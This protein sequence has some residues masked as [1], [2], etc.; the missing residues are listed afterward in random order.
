MHLE[1]PGTIGGA[2]REFTEVGGHSFHAL[3]GRHGP[4]RGAN[5]LC[6]GFL[7]EGLPLTA[8]HQK[9]PT[10]GQA[11]HV[12]HEIGAALF[13]VEVTGLE[14]FREGAVGDFVDHPGRGSEF[15]A[16]G[17]GEEWNPCAVSTG[18]ID[19]LVTGNE[20]G[21]LADFAWVFGLAR[22]SGLFG[23]GCHDTMLWSKAPL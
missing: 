4:C 6:I 22:F 2:G 14:D 8:A 10:D 21:W 19:G 15:N 17:G 18:P 23:D 16:R 1:T 9:H 7:G 20:V 5:H 11:G 3:E 12:T 13:G